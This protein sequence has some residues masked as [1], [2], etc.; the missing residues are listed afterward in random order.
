M[1]PLGKVKRKWSPEMAYAIGLIATDGCVSKD[2]RHLE[3]NSKDLDQVETFKKCL[4]LSNTITKKV[5]GYTKRKD[6]FHIQFG[7][8]L[9]CDWLRSIGLSSRKSKTI[10][11]LKVPDTYFRDF[12]RGCF[13]GDGTVWSHRDK[14]WKSSLLLVSSFCSASPVFINWIRKETKKKCGIKGSI[15]ASGK[16]F[17]LKYCKRET[18][19]LFKMMYYSANLP[20]LKRK[21]SRYLDICAQDK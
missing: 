9:F 19:V 18:H 17:Q 12:L 6:Y 14:R 10:A 7:D 15:D 1:H 13:D 8:K 4:G 16:V 11:A 20:F 2:G 3:F 21:Y 5:S